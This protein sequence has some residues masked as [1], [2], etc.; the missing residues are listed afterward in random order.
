MFDWNDLRAFL[1]VAETGSTLAAGRVLK[2]SQTTAARR[3]AALEAALGLTL[4]ERRQAG[5]ALTAA[6]EALLPQAKA[7]A[8]AA[9]GFADAVS[10]QSREAGGTVRL[11]T[12]E[13]YTLTL[14]P[15][16]L[17]DL[18]EAHP[19]IRI[20]L[21]STDEL[22]DLSTGV[23][24]IALRSTGNAHGAGLVGRRIA[25]D[26]WTVFCN[27]DYAARHGVPETLADLR[28]HSLI[29][30]GGRGVGPLY[31]AWL[32]KHGLEQAVIMEQT[33]VSG[34]LASVRSGLGIAVLPSFVARQQP[35]LIQCL[36]HHE[37]DGLALWLLTHERVRHMPRVR[38][39][40]DFVYER[41]KALSLS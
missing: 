11:T 26:P 41:L 16:I 6:G 15:P 14:L 21:E 1:A 12:H 30:G 4:F 22:R 28:N 35:E 34:L 36:P 9:G 20:E 29:A 32:R 38:V 17:R 13:I 25:A 33:S 19:A 24:D 3:I 2:V 40:I 23:A 8:A 18:H 7:V 39:V 37:E 31:H 10:A 5:Y 27:R